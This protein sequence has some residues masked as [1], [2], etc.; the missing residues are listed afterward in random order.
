M[1][2]DRLRPDLLRAAL[3]EAVRVRGC[4]PAEILAAPDADEELSSHLAS[5]LFCR[6]ERDLLVELG[7]EPEH[8]PLGE[9]EAGAP[10][11]VR[12]G[13]VRPLSPELAGWGP[14]GRFYKPPLVLV[15]EPVPGMER[16]VRVCLVHDF[17]RLAGP[18]D[19]ELAPGLFAES[20]NTFPVPIHRLGS[21][22]RMVHRTALDRVL[23][24][25]G[26]KE[27]PA[28][29]VS[30]TED[31]PLESSYVTA[32]RRLEVE[33]VAYFV[34]GHFFGGSRIFG[35][36]LSDNPAILP[37]ETAGDPTRTLVALEKV[38]M[39]GGPFRSGG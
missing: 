14:R 26:T 12:P 30:A 19:V 34:L 31:D 24:A 27:S 13:Q 7:P 1:T 11:T 2:K 37:I 17:P 35:L 22:V 6:E 32:F 5:C 9:G 25:L 38:G 3:E 4:P 23:Q 15:L 16:A 18:G 29:A 21:A 10:G 33:T 20:W 39:V 28:A 8:P 36:T